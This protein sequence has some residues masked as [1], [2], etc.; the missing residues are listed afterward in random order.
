MLEEVDAA[1]ENRRMQS[2]ADAQLLASLGK[3]TD[4]I[5]LKGHTHTQVT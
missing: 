5:Y 1:T 3:V 4:Y 2:A